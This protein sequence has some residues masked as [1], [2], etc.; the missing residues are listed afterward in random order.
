MKP[1]RDTLIL[2]AMTLMM[3]C[4]NESARVSRIAEQAMLE[5]SRQ[6]EEMARLNREIAAA[7]ERLVEAD[8]A[9]RQEILAAHQSMVAQRDALER[10]RREMAAQ[11][12][13]QSWLAPLFWQFGT[14]LLCLLPVALAIL[15]LRTNAADELNAV[16]EILIHELVSE[17]PRLLPPPA[18]VRRLSVTDDGAPPDAP[19]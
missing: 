15:V 19:A 16:N 7:T 12:V 18:S 5:Q 4:S 17:D 14:L 2:L 11:R 1:L 13:R 9:A 3:G 8:A 6:N 10:E